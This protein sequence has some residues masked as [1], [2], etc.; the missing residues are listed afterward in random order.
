MS[1]KVQM[2]QKKCYD[3]IPP[4]QKGSVFLISNISLTTAAPLVNF[5]FILPEKNIA[6]QLEII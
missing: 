4:F 3:E 5:N 2:Q 6:E 1:T